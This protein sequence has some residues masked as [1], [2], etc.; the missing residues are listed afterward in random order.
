MAQV[1]KEEWLMV[2]HHGTFVFWF[3]TGVVAEQ[4]WSFTQINIQKAILKLRIE[5]VPPIGSARLKI[6]YFDAKDLAW[7]EMGMVEK[8]NG[9]S[10][11]KEVDVTEICRN[12]PST[13]WHAIVGCW[14]PWAFY[15]TCLRSRALLYLEYTGGT[16]SVNGVSSSTPM[17]QTELASV[18][19][20]MNFMMQFMMMFMMMSLM[21]S[22]MTAITGMA[23]GS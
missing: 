21:V 6:E 3:G 17:G 8:W 19:E 2:D 7:K 20:M 15:Y 1:L 23:G 4:S 13:K 16:P 14:Y 11:Y 22:M 18:A 5:N 9:G 12:N 10:A